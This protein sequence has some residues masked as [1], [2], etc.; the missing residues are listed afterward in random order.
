MKPLL[1]K[2]W[3]ED[4]E[5]GAHQRRAV[6]DMG[7][8]FRGSGEIGKCGIGEESSLGVSPKWRVFGRKPKLLS[9]FPNFHGV[10]TS[11]P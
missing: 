7:R 9:V 3:G 6:A 11:A 5:E 8:G 4:E 1:W 2:I 10:L